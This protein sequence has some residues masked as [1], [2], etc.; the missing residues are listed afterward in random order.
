MHPVRGVLKSRAGPLAGHAAASGTPRP[1]P[2]RAGRA[3][4]SSGCRPA[5]LC[6]NQS[7]PGIFSQSDLKQQS[8]W[9]QTS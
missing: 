9:P 2:E 7:S 4:A 6:H 5:L 8:G 3:R 1:V